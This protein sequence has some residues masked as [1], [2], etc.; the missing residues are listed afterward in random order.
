MISLV[1]AYVAPTG[2]DGG[3]RHRGQIDVQG[4]AGRNSDSP[5]HQFDVHGEAVLGPFF[6]RWRYTQ[7]PVLVGI[8]LTARMEG[9]YLHVGEATVGLDVGNQFHGFRHNTL[10]IH[11]ETVGNELLHLVVL[12]LG[13]FH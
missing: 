5:Q 3:Q 11:R 7:R 10:R 13:H 4:T 2:W 8:T 1:L 6:R 9:L 12:R